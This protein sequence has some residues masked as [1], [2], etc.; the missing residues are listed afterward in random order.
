MSISTLG[1]KQMYFTLKMD[2]GKLVGMLEVACRL[3]LEVACRQST[4]LDDLNVL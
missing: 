3:H 4:S 1:Y 2:I